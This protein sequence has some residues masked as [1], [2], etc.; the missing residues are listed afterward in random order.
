MPGPGTGQVALNWAFTPPGLVRP[1]SFRLLFATSARDATSAAIAD[2][3]NH[4][5]NDAGAGH[6]AIPGLKNGF[7]VIASTEAVDAKDN[8]GLTGTGVKIYWMGSS[9]KVADN[10][11]DLLDGSWD[12]ESPTDKNGNA[13]SVQFFWTGSDDDGTEGILKGI[14]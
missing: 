10:Y 14:M 13:S 6:S 1:G 4:A 12:N 7:R 2:Y 5:I 11:A 3:N 8:A 9:E